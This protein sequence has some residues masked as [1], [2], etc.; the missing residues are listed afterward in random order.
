MVN[1]QIK[2]MLTLCLL[3]LLFAVAAYDLFIA[4]VCPEALISVHMTPLLKLNLSTHK[5]S[6]R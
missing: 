6:R 4:Q 3:L 2:Q 1:T 5:S